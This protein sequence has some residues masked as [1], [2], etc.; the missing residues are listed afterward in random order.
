MDAIASYDTKTTPT[1]QHAQFQAAFAFFNERLFDGR[2]P[3]AM[4]TMQRRK[5]AHGFHRQ[6]SFAAKSD[7]AT[8]D[9]IALNPDSLSRNDRAILSTLVHEMVHL[10]QRAFGK[11]GRGAYHNRQW[12]EWMERIGLIPSSTGMPG[13]KK[14]GQKVSHY[15]VDGGCFDAACAELTSGGFALRWQGSPDDPMPKRDPSK[16]K[17]TCPDCEQNAWAKADSS[18]ICGDCRIDMEP[19]Q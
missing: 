10:E 16:V 2:L 9:E 15:I 3:A 13:G 11:P 1:D 14:T 6:D 4:I 12:A 5:N 8:I 19:V 17:F 18:L 7:A